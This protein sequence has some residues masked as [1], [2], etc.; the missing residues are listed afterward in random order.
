MY[1]HYVETLAECLKNVFADMTGVAVMGVKVGAGQLDSGRLPVAQ[2]I[3][4][5]GKD[6]TLRGQFILGFPRPELAIEVAGALAANMGL[7][8]PA[9]ID[10]VAID[11]LAEFMNTVVGR[12]ISAWDR[13][14]MPVSFGVPS[15]L[16]RADL[17]SAQDCDTEN[18][19]V[20]LSMAVSTLVFHVNFSEEAM[21]AA[22]GPRI[23]IAEDSATLRMFLQKA[24]SEAGYE[25][26]TAQDGEEAV[27]LYHQAQPALALMDLVM[28]KM[29]GLDAMMA[30]RDESPEAQFLVLTSSDRRDEVVTAKTL[31]V[32]DYLIKPVNKDRLLA[33]VA[34]ALA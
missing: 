29:G 33:A 28:P 30:I 4:Y 19:A 26:V 34:E 21:A 6:H 23:M 1:L 13:M 25:V 17:G 8:K 22:A 2:V 18:Y 3:A 24:L 27:E 5:Q 11:L 16:Q 9:K 32:V 7:D 14:G 10:S 15:A 12:T 31:G 20:S